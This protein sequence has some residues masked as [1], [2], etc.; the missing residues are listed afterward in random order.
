[1]KK[2]CYGN[3][4][5]VVTCSGINASAPIFYFSVERKKKF[6]YILNDFVINLIS[7]KIFTDKSTPFY[8]IVYHHIRRRSIVFGNARFDFCSNQIYFYQIL[9]TFYPIYPN[10]S[11]FYPNFTQY[12]ILPKFA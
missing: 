3:L 6:T 5:F 1:V 8:G 11:K 9:S 7:D 2:I 10:L 12:P 4:T